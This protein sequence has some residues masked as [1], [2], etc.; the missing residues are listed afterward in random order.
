[1]KS[2]SVLPEERQGTC[3]GRSRVSSE[4]RGR[5]RRRTFQDAVYRL[6]DLGKIVNSDSSKRTKWFNHVRGRN[7]RSIVHSEVVV[8]STTNEQMN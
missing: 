2:K 7:N 5:R 4:N 6:T 1:M 8:F 3:V